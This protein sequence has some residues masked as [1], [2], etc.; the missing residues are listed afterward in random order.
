MFSG[1]VLLLCVPFI[2]RQWQ[3]YS[4]HEANQAAMLPFAD[5][6]QQAKRIEQETGL[7]CQPDKLA[8]HSSLSA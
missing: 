6:L 5:N 1:I 2:I 7:V 8:A 4:S 3:R